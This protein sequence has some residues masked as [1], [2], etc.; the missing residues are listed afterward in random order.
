MNNRTVNLL[1]VEDNKSEAFLIKEYLKKSKLSHFNIIN[2]Y[3]LAEAKES[4]LKN[5]IELILLDLSLPDSQFPNTLEDII[6]NF[7]HIP[8][9]V[10]TGFD[11]EKWAMQSIRKGAQDYILKRDITAGFLDKT[12]LYSIERHKLRMLYYEAVK[13]I[14]EKE[15]NLR[16]LID[17]M[18]DGM[19]VL[20]DKCLVRFVNKA[21]L[22][23]MGLNRQDVVSKPF[24]DKFCILRVTEEPS[25]IEIE[26]KE[27]QIYYFQT[28]LKPIKWQEE[29]CN[30]VSFRDVTKQVKAQNRVRTIAKVMESAMELS[31]IHI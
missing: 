19:V 22:D 27:G 11:D 18:P 2:A 23:L 8:V 17:N 3:T 14:Q 29:N 15:E 10:L 31:L 1:I 13:N 28:R 26:I 16:I 6:K 9:V 25:E 21:M 5:V 20:N 30:L 4:L 12:L 7:N 24:Y